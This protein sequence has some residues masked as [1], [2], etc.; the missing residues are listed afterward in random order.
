MTD[1][2]DNYAAAHELLDGAAHHR[3]SGDPAMALAVAVEGVGRAILA[4]AAATAMSGESRNWRDRDAW[5]AV[6][7]YGTG[8]EDC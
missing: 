7:G 1:G 2:P 4:L 5:S 8:V 3:G 6:L